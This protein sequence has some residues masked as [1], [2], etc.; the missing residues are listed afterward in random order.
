VGQ[1]ARGLPFLEKS[2][3]IMQMM[4]GSLKLSTHEMKTTQKV[5]YSPPTLSQNKV[6]SI[7][8]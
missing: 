4:E 2:M 7:A 8:F 1:A 5:S 3:Q 6:L